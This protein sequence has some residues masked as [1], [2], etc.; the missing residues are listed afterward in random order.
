MM[1][2]AFTKMGIIFDEKTG[3]ITATTWSGKLIANMA[4]RDG[5]FDL[6]GKVGEHTYKLKKGMN[7]STKS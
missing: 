5:H 3:V 4:Y 7:E 2:K 1:E 6:V